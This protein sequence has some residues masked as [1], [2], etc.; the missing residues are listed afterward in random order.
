M[1][2]TLYLLLD[3]ETGRMSTGLLAAVSGT[4][5]ETGIALPEKHHSN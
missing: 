2:L 1:I 4:A 3:T 5:V